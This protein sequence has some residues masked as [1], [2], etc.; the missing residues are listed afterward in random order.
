MT[1]LRRA[2]KW[3]MNQCITDTGGEPHTDTT[4]VHGKVTEP[5]LTNPKLQNGHIHSGVHDIYTG[6]EF[7]T[8]IAGVHN[9]G[10]NPALT[11]PE[12]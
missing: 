2:S 11:T 9:K 10:T 7:H 6:G 3:K 1:T 4:G 8:D 12:L 5:V